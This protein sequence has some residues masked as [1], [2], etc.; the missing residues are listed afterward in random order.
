[1]DAK[2][3]LLSKYDSF[4]D[5]YY[6]DE[7]TQ[8][9]RQEERKLTHLEKNAQ[10]SVIGWSVILA[11]SLT[12]MLVIDHCILNPVIPA[13]Y[14]RYFQVG[15]VALMGFLAIHIISR[16]PYRMLISYSEQ[17][18]K[19]II[20]LVRISGTIIVIAAA[21]SYLSQDRIIAA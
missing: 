11:A 3:Y 10:K 12:V 13:L 20:S 15:D 21:I 9:R 7:E 5:N 8:S 17:I 2:N 1:M 6:N 4:T 19:S 18:A 14:L 16:I